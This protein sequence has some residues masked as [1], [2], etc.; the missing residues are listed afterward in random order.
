MELGIGS[1]AFRWSIGSAAFAPPVAL[2]C[3]DLVEQ[4]AALGCT[5]LQIADS[6]ELDSMSDEGLAVLREQAA[7]VGV[8]L[9][10]GTSGATVERLL[11]NLHIAE[12]LNADIVRLVLDSEDAHPTLP[13]C[14]AVLREVVPRYVDSGIAIAIENHF[15]TSSTD[16]LSLIEN[17]GSSAVG[18]CLDTANSIMAGEWPETTIG[19]LADY[20]LCAHVKDYAIVPHIHGTGG[21]LVGRPMGTGWL[22]TGAVLASLAGADAKADGRL[23]VLL[24]QWFPIQEDP[25]S[26]VAEEQEWRQLG[27]EYLRSFIPPADP[28]SDPQPQGNPKDD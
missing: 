22:D 3:A 27:V 1:Y 19:L 24:E 6:R 2:R 17:V 7:S 28:G 18:V 16:M 9:Q 12:S 26:T 10:T 5:L 14:E 11:A 13:E 23:G 21:H 4:T 20:A 8:R 25:A 15:L